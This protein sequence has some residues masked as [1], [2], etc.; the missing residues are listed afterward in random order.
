MYFA[1]SP[2]ESRTGCKI[3][4]LTLFTIKIGQVD[5]LMGF[6]LGIKNVGCLNYLISDEPVVILES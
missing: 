5:V 2:R 3:G 1:L 4:T 6:V